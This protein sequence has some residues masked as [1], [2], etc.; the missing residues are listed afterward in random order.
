VVAK[1]VVHVG[2]CL[3]VQADAVGVHALLG[4][5]L[6]RLSGIGD[7]RGFVGHVYV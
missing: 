5:F 2:I 1:D 6:N 3:R 7:Q 4:Q